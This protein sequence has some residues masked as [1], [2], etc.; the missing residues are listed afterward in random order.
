MMFMPT[1]NFLIVTWTAV[2]RIRSLDMFSRTLTAWSLPQ[3]TLA[4]HKGMSLHLP[5][6]IDSGKLTLPEQ[7]LI[8]AAFYVTSSENSNKLTD[9]LVENFVKGNLQ[10]HSVYQY[11]IVLFPELPLKRTRP[12]FLINLPLPFSPDVCAWR[13][14]HCNVNTKLCSI[15]KEL[16]M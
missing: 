2:R 5:C 14:V 7:N 13:S 8:D 12:H 4:K 6:Y 10:E 3:S 9:L 11:C 1:I 16:C 15:E